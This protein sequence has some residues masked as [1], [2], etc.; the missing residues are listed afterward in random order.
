MDHHGHHES[1]DEVERSVAALAEPQGR[2]CLQRIILPR[3]G[4]PLDV[5][6]L[7]LVESATNAT[8]AHS[9]S[10]TTLHIG[11]DSEVSFATYFNAFAAA[12]WRRWSVVEEVV[13]RLTVRG[14]GRV[15]LYR[16][17]I[18]GSRIAVCGD[19]VG[20]PGD[21]DGHDSA[22]SDEHAG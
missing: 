9:S 8:R 14:S 3:P 10:R 2:E 17:K 6:S 12:Y 22:Q 18:D 5:R 19:V 16:S 1:V 4:E 15:D 20:D 21:A 13:L 11:V 7:Y